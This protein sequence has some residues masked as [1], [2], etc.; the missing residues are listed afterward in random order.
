MI[1][2][3]DGKVVSKKKM[4][5]PKMQ[6]NSSTLRFVNSKRDVRRC[7]KVRRYLLAISYVLYTDGGECFE[8]GVQKE[9]MK[10]GE[11]GMNKLPPYMEGLHDVCVCRMKSEER[12]QELYKGELEIK[13]FAT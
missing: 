2:L 1:F 10:K 12:D 5:I 13:V 8:K 4:W 6:E 11:I 7:K 3:K 9:T